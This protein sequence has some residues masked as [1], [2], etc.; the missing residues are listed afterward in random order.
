MTPLQLKRMSQVKRLERNLSKP[1]KKPKGAPTLKELRQDLH[2][3]QMMVRVD[4]HAARAG[5]EKCREIAKKMREL[6]KR[7]P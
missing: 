7:K 1:V 4:L 6:Q 2:Y 3:Y 5:M